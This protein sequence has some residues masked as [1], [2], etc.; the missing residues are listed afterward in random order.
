MVYILIYFIL[1]LG[2]I[3]FLYRKLFRVG[4][5]EYLVYR[6]SGGVF[7]IT[8]SFVA[9]VF[10]A[11]SVFGLAGWGY[12]FGWNAIWWTL[13]GV[14][15]LIILGVF[16]VN[17]I[18][19][20]RGFTIIDIIE[21]NFGRVIKIFSSVVLFVAWISVLA[22]QIIAGG[23][24]VQIVVSN[25]VLSFLL[26]AFI[27]GIYTIIWGQVGA[28][29]T[30]FLQVVLMFIGLII[31]FSLVFSKVNYN[32]EAMKAEFGFNEIFNFP[33]WLTV[34]VS[35]GLSYLFGPDIYSRIFSS[36][37][38]TIARKSIFWASFLILV[39]SSIIVSIGVVGREIFKNVD[40]PDN[41]IPILS[42][43]LV[44]DWVKPIVMV[45][46]ISIPLSGADV[47]LITSTSIFSK[48]L[49]PAVFGKKDIFDN[50]WFIRIIT[51]FVISLSTFVALMG[52]GIIPTLLVAYKVFSSTIAPLVFVS[53][54]SRLLNKKIVLTQF[55]KL[56]V[57][58]VMLVISL[59]IL[60]GELAFHNIVFPNYTIYLL[61]FNTLL[62]SYFV[63]AKSEK[64]K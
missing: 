57:F 12:K 24:I 49:L 41:I 63:F 61:I 47:I 58:S 20:F 11:S 45:A 22:G 55:Q 14:V 53:L 15:F 44:P 36:K 42:M 1:V 48:N 23:N 62:I 54:L 43:S 32:F 9:L 4:S 21:V 56:V 60:V 8:M 5:D 50:I 16:F 52:K 30:S 46:L 38:S 25:K 27:F 19:S 29:K 10:G 28:I 59:Y 13:S 34:F 40:N 37:D 33:F 31:I 18:Y 2:L 51:I 17:V 39:I 3:V 6:R 26:F 35:V 64:Q 7:E